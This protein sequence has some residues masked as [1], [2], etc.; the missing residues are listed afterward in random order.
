MI[1]AVMAPQ[2]WAQF[3]V[4]LSNLTRDSGVG[5]PNHDTWRAPRNAGQ[6]GESRA[7]GMASRG[8]YF[9]PP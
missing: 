5:R 2:D 3:L 6:Q 7:A 8:S 1:P 9:G 4:A